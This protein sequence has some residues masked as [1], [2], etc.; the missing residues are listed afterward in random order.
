MAVQAGVPIVPVA[1]RNTDRLMGKGT[2]EA[3]AGTIE[4]VLLPPVSTAGLSTDDEVKQLVDQVH[5]VIA[6]ELCWPG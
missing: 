4:M 3:K 1:I 6:K 2:G 5:A